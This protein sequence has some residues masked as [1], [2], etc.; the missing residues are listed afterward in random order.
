MVWGRPVRSN[1]IRRNKVSFVAWGLGWS[2][3]FSRRLRRKES[4]ALRGQSALVTDGDVARLGG[5]NAQ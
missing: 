2:P 5:M 3:S 4:I 1:E